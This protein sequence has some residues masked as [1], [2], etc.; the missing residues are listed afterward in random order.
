MKVRDDE[1]TE[2]D[3]L[4]QDYCEVEVKGGS[5]NLHGKVNIL[6]QS[7][8]SRERLN[9]FSLMSDQSCIIQVR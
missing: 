2:L 8:L 7:Y 9:S 5:E 1:L 6:L 4:V 3:S